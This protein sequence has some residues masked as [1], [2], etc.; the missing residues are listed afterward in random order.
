MVEF[1][2]LDKLFNRQLAA[3]ELIHAIG[4][5]TAVEYLRNIRL[6]QVMLLTSSLQLLRYN[7]IT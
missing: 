7:K 3:T 1:R 5:L 6:R 2:E 4:R